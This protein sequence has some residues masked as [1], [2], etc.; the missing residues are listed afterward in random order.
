VTSLSCDGTTAFWS[1]ASSNGVDFTN[2]DGR[3]DSVPLVGGTPRVLATGFGNP[4]G[5]TLVGGDLF[6]GATGTFINRTTSNTGGVWH[7]PKAGGESTAVVDHAAWIGAVSVDET[8]VAF[9]EGVGGDPLGGRWAL[10][11]RAR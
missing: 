9:V 10:K 7:L 4:H 8:H 11:L 2:P 3:I 1:L 6:F 5:L